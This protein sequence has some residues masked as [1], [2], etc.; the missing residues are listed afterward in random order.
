MFKLLLIHLTKEKHLEKTM[1]N[2]FVDDS[3]FAQIRELLKHAMVDSIE[4]LYIVLGFPDLE[5]RQNTLSFDKYFETTY[6][7]ERIQL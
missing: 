3:L 2:M 1:Y 4:V 6:S 5:R 7:F